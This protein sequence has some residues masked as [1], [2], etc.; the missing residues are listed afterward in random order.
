[1]I[2]FRFFGMIALSISV[3][4]G[5]IMNL[6]FLLGGAYEGGAAWVSALGTVVPPLG[7]IFGWVGLFL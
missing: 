1:M 5:W 4:A 7:V 2:M 3:I 6:V